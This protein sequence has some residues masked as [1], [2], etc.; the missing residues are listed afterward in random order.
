[1]VELDAPRWQVRRHSL[2]ATVVGC[3][4]IAAS[5]LPSDHRSL[6]V[7]LTASVPAGLYV[8]TA[9]PPRTGDF[10]LARLPMHLRRLAA[11]RSYLPLHRLLVKII[12][13][14]PGDVVC[15]LGARVWTSRHSAVWALRTDALARPLL[16]WRGCRR[17]RAG[18]LFVLGHHPASFDSRYFGPINRQSVLAAVR[19]VLVFRS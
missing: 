19:P 2:L 16:N 4:A 14:S 12:A 7:N 15:R 13:A 17:L 10:V 11:D 1:M 6:I 9:T 8:S 3:V 5:T 18:E